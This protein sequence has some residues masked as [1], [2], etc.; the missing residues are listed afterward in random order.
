MNYSERPDDLIAD[1]RALVAEAAAEKGR[2]HAAS[3]ELLHSLLTL[4]I[5]LRSVIEETGD[6]D[7]LD[8]VDLLTAGTWTLIR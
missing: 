2:L 8:R 7:L 3:D 4:T 5:E 1:A 6:Q